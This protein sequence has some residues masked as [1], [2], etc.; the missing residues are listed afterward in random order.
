MALTYNN[1]PVKW[2]NE[3][4]PPSIDLKT[5]GF[6]AGYKPPA[7]VFNNQWHVTGECISELQEK[8]SDVDTQVTST[9]SSVSTLNDKITDLPI[10]SLAGQSVQPTQGTTVTA[11]TAATIISDL[12]NR[13]FTAQDKVVNGN[14]ASGD[15]S[16]A[17]GQGTTASGSISTAMG[18]YTTASG[19][20]STAFGN[21]T[22]ASANA[23]TAMGYDTTASAMY[24][25]AMG[26][27]TVANGNNST[28]MG[29]ESTASGNTSFAMGYGCFASGDYSTAMGYVNTSQA[30]QFKAGH[31]SKS[32]T[33][34][35]T[36]G[37]TGDAF[38]IGNGTEGTAANCFRV[39]Y[40]GYVYGGKT[41]GANAADVAELYEWQDGNPNNEDRRG[42]FV[43]LDGTK[44]KLASPTDTYIKG[45][46][47]ALPCLVGDAYSDEWQGKYLKDVFGVPLTHTV[48]YDAKYKERETIDPE[49]G[50]TITETVCIREAYDAE[51][52]ILNPDYD[53]TK[54]YV[55]REQRP[56]FDY[57]SNWGKLVLVDDGTCEVN[58]F[59]TVGN[60]GKATKADKQTAY[61]VMERRDD[62]HIYVS[63]G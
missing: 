4:T 11:G 45:V 36:S 34:G 31:Y 8:L 28:A 22:T 21:R 43:T 57:V 60:G 18:V 58:G 3:G 30:N 1:K 33:A 17:I 63:V 19:S 25:T 41:F 27:G 39:G 44:I 61:R 37:T 56:E 15:Y 40:D 55:P 48:H 47:S 12:R 50:E 13:S 62:T 42:L 46:I 7:S 6:Q 23:T 5:N 29:N 52:Y 10:K 51:E 35:T 9:E 49:T 2:E 54:E 20:W 14:V 16:L 38:I 53:P 26:Y 24:S 59:A 32:G